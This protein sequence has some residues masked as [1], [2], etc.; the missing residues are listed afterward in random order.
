MKND[1]ANHAAC[2]AENRKPYITS[3]VVANW[4]Y[5]HDVLAILYF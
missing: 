5:S 3:V 4:S 1:G 2:V